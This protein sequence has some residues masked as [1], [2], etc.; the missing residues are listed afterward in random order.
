MEPTPSHGGVP[1]AVFSMM[2]D[3]VRR[4]VWLGLQTLTTQ[5]EPAERTAPV[6]VVKLPQHH[7]AGETNPASISRRPPA[8][9][10]IE[11]HPESLFNR[12]Y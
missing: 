1:T 5:R 2:P 8:P 10:P 9:G 11:G 6:L 3:N 4:T 12:A 7:E